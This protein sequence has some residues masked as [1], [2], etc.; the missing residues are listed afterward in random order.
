MKTKR[1]IL[2]E[3]LGISAESMTAKLADNWT[4]IQIA[5]EEY[6]SQFVSSQSRVEMPSEEEF[7]K[8]LLKVNEYCV[9]KSS[10]TSEDMVTVKSAIIAFKEVFKVLSLLPNRETP[11]EIPYCTCENPDITTYTEHGTVFCFDCRKNIRFPPSNKPV[12]KKSLHTE[13]EINPDGYV[14]EGGIRPMFN[15]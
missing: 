11:K 4:A 9:Y 5:M 15:R 12:S 7:K 14:E 1:E 13:I 3:H 6:K 2:K 10:P 8:Q